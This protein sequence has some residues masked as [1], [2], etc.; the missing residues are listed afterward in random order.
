MV[1]HKP[2]FLGIFNFTLI[3]TNFLKL[4]PVRHVSLLVIRA[5][6]I[7]HYSKFFK[8]E[9]C[10]VQHVFS[11]LALIEKIPTHSKCLSLY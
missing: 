2:Q 3:L 4:S 8:K 6:Q 5:L 11:H 1:F 7:S 9:F 10:I